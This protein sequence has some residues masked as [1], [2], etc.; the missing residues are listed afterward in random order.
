MVLSNVSPLS[1]VFW[2]MARLG[3]QHMAR[4]ILLLSPWRRDSFPR[5]LVFIGPD[6]SV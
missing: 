5:I 4:A 6:E 3:R 1:D 2:H